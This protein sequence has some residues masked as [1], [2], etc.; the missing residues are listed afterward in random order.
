MKH[1]SKQIYKQ[2]SQAKKIVLVPHQNPDGDTLGSVAAT[3]QLLKKMNKEYITFCATS[4]SEKLA[5]LPH[6][7]EVTNDEQIWQDENIDTVLVFDSGDLRYAGVADFVSKMKSKPIVMNIDHHNTNEYYGDFNLVM[8]EESSTTAILYRFF[9]YNNIEV[10]QKMA[11]GLLTGLMTD[12]DN[13]TNSGTTIA[14]MLIAGKLIERGADVKKIKESIFKD[15]SVSSLRLWGE[16]F[17]RLTHH[18]ETDIVHT[19]VTVK[20]L[21]KHNVLDSAIEGIANFMNNL[22]E[23]KAG[24]ILKELEDGNVKG[25]FRTTRNDTDV[26]AYAKHLGGGGHKKAAGFTVEGPIETAAERVLEA[27]LHI[28]KLQVA[29]AEI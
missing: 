5:F 18:E 1:V 3:M 16:V 24:L 4:V 12:T 27:V 22:Q 14:S 6:V 8:D 2:L 15:K 23:G 9:I 13:F 10:D 19:F 7:S 28:D 20:D 11:T 17:A 26:S 29:Q 25:S 21:S